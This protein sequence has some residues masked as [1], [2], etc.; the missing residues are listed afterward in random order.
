MDTGHEQQQRGGTALRSRSTRACDTCKRKRQ[1]CCGSNPCSGCRA[2][3]LVCTYSVPQRKRG[4]KKEDKMSIPAHS[5]DSADSFDPSTVLIRELEN[6]Q[7]DLQERVRNMESILTSILRSKSIVKDEGPASTSASAHKT[8]TEVDW[9]VSSDEDDYEEDPSL[10]AKRARI[11]EVVDEENENAMTR[12]DNGQPDSSSRT[13]ASINPDISHII[14]ALN[15]STNPES[16]RVTMDLMNQWQFFSA[17]SAT[18]KP[19]RSNSHDKLDK[20]FRG[21]ALSL[22]R[23]MRRGIHQPASQPPN[24]VTSPSEF[25]ASAPTSPTGPVNGGSSSSASSSAYSQHQSSTQ[26]AGGEYTTIVEDLASDAIL[27]FGSTSTTTSSA[28]RQSPRFAGGIMNISLS[29]EANPPS[30]KVLDGDYS[31]PCSME[32]VLHLVG[33][34]FKHV[35]PYFPMIHKVR[36]FQQLKEKRTD[37]FNLLLNSMCAL[38]SQQCRD[39]NDWGVVNPVELHMAFF[40]RARVLLGQQFDWPHINNVQALLLLCMVGQ[41]TNI[42]ATSYHYIGI[43]HRLAV[44][45]G[46]HRNLDNLKHP[47]LDS[48]LL[49]AMRATW[50]CLYILDQ[51]TSVVEG[52]PSA[53]S[54]D[55]WDTPFPTCTS[56]EITMLRH[57]VGLCEILGRIGNAVN[58]PGKP[59]LT[60]R[61]S[62]FPHLASTP[63]APRDLKKV[64]DEINANL[65][66]WYSNLPPELAQRPDSNSTWSFHHHLY[67]MFHT[68]SV[69]LHRL[70]VSKF[71]QTCA[72]NACEISRV[73]ECLPVPP[74]GMEAKGK[75]VYHETPFVFVLPLIVYSALTASTLFLDLTLAAR[76]QDVTTKKRKSRAAKA[77]SLAGKV[78]PETGRMAAKQLRKSLVAFDR[79]KTTSLFANYYGQLIVEVLRND[80]VVLPPPDEDDEDS[81]PSPANLNAADTPAAPKNLGAG[82]FSFFSSSDIQ[83]NPQS[84]T[85]SAAA[86]AS[87]NSITSRIASSMAA[88]AEGVKW[89]EFLHFSPKLAAGQMAPSS[90]SF[91]TAASQ[92]APSAL[93]NAASQMAPASLLNAATQMAPTSLINAASNMWGR[94]NS[95]FGVDSMD[96]AQ[97]APML[98]GGGRNGGMGLHPMHQQHHHQHHHQGPT[99]PL[100]NNVMTLNENGDEAEF[101]GGPAE[102]AN[103]LATSSNAPKS[104][105]SDLFADLLN[106]ISDNQHQHAIWPDLGMPGRSTE[107]NGSPE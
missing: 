26:P 82:L 10:G 62:I 47:A 91:M 98:G 30:T 22:Q 40:E 81:S 5:L 60:S 16:M 94:F 14:N 55:E 58:R 19:Q 93:I 97:Q 6:P 85:L 41:G 43:A 38:M 73:L 77:A 66:A 74:L 8:L 50:F 69:L 28:W 46:M 25:L 33:L 65:A 3:R 56:F 95:N 61:P 75:G 96:Q 51:Y 27:F 29:F 34:Y 68:A 37:H 39:L 100:A 92:M 20:G 21:I 67:A 17:S 13:N 24:P 87:Q 18:V 42:N 4:P 71:D 80:Q 7:N 86:A 32:L 79:L 57:H 1:K 83:Q 31:P 59:G 64:I 72:M 101:G 45:L 104:P 89:N 106:P 103:T 9:N 84:T 107:S 48:E 76:P 35:H 105:F 90:T 44:E 49:E 70:D 11:S 52:R 88:V 54:D 102:Q 2:N 63:A 15:A 99:S 12:F 78:T 36:F 53:I 23:K